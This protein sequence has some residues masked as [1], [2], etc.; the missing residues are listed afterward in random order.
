MKL[1]ALAIAALAA[2][3]VLTACS[4]P[5]EFSDGEIISA[6]QKRE[7]TAAETYNYADGA[8]EPP[9]SY[10]SYAAAAQDF[11]FK[12]FRAKYDGHG[13]KSFA[14]SPANTFLQLSLLANGASGDVK[15][16]L[17][18]GLGTMTVED[19]NICSSY[20][21][22]R[23]E[24]V[25][26]P[27]KSGQADDYDSF[28][29]NHASLFNN[30]FINKDNEITKAF[31]QTDAD[32][33]GT[34][35]I[36]TDFS[37]N[38]FSEKQEKLFENYTGSAVEADKKSNFYTT[39]SLSVLDTWLSELTGT[40]TDGFFTSEESYLSTDKA[41]GVIKYSKSNPLKLL[42]VMP[43]GK[44]TLDDYVKSFDGNEF[45]A[46]IESQ[47]VKNTVAAKLPNFTIESGEEAKPLS[48]LLQKCGFYTLF[49]D[50]AKFKA[51]NIA[52]NLKLSEMYEFEPSLFFAANTI[53]TPSKSQP[54]FS[55]LYENSKP[56]AK[57]SGKKTVIFDKPFIFLLIDNESNI[58]VM[59]G[60]YSD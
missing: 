31:L 22:S 53:Y 57:A 7:K 4:N 46:L 24:E 9:K 35:I 45:S 17:L 40:E 27:K 2:A 44:T 34:N 42:A 36:R 52:G 23:M 29:N 49:S 1:K 54:G 51:M 48:P 30:V 39:S 33:Y 6:A 60:A 59:A 10:N 50:D 21:K 43:K 16:E 55:D 28:K 26:K 58:P 32:F 25:A 41:E 5:G 20:F 15:N 37:A 19:L 56:A 14:F 3:T 8:E 12:L 47:D 38:D 11:S 13:G 18:T